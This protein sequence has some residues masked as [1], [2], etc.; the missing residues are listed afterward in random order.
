[1][2]LS[3]CAGELART[4]GGRAQRRLRHASARFAGEVVL[5]CRI[6]CDLVRA[7]VWRD[8]GNEVAKAIDKMEG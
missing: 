7:L 4:L 2:S 8:H 5:E 1:M 6:S 3:L